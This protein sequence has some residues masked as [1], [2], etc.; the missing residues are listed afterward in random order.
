MSTDGPER[1]AHGRYRSFNLKRE[2]TDHLADFTRSHR[3]F[4]IRAAQE[5]A[6]AERYRSFLSL[7]IVHGGESADTDTPVELLQELHPMITAD[8]RVT[9]LVSGVENNRFAVLLIE[10][11]AE[12]ADTYRKRLEFQVDLLR[13]KASDNGDGISLEIERYT[14]PEHL[15]ET[16]SLA[17]Q[18][19]DLYQESSNR[20][21]V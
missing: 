13:S 9:D 11:D 18:L 19:D 7:I 14:F 2:F 17:Q 5:L 6:R 10:T 8:S 12:G 20:P 1:F 21:V 15:A 3:S 16:T 4:A